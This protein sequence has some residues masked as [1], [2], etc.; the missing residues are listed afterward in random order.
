MSELDNA[1]RDAVNGAGVRTIEIRSGALRWSRQDVL[2][3]IRNS[4][5]EAETIRN[6]TLVEGDVARTLPAFDE[7]VALAILEMDL[8]ASTKAALTALKGKMSRGGIIAPLNYGSKFRATEQAVAE[9]FPDT[10]LE[11]AKTDPTKVF[12]RF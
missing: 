10:T 8:Y 2:R 3:F 7:K 11:T 12:I 4:G 6:L 9:V 5:I 1:K